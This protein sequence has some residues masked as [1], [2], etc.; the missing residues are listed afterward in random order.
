MARPTQEIFDLLI[1]DKEADSNLDAFDSVSQ[2]A[3]WRAMLFVVALSMNLFEQLLDIFKAD[4]TEIALGLKIGT[5]AWLRGEA[6]KFQFGDTIELID[7]IPAY[8]IL[9]PAKQIITAAAVVEGGDSK[10]T[11]KVAKGT[12]PDLSALD[13]A[14][15]I[16]F[17]TYIDAIHFA[18]TQIVIASNNADRI[19]ITAEIFYNGEIGESTTTVNVIAAIDAFGA[20]FTEEEFNGT[21]L[22]TKLVD[23]IQLAVGV[24]DIEIT[25]LKGR[26]STAPLVSALIF[27]RL[28]LTGAGYF[29]TEDTVG[30]TVAETLTFTL[31]T[32]V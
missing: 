12:P 16:A 17:T 10:V 13:P 4:V 24:E 11:V 29:V 3:L 20:A 7:F 27:T 15:L 18:G 19:R 23:A 14:E 2:T 26:I 5:C 25:E 28:Y 32:D 8:P 30:S 21:V 1:A 9:D 22:V 31:F 6:L